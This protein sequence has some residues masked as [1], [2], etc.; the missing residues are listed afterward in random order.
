MT[1]YPDFKVTVLFNVKLLE[2]GTSYIYDGRPTESRM[3]SIERR[4]FQ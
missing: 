3:W 2:N 1:S 4:H